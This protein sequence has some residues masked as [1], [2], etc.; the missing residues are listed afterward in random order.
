MIKLFLTTGVETEE[1][2]PPQQQSNWQPPA[3]EHPVRGQT[4]E[5]LTRKKKP[6]TT[7]A[8][9]KCLNFYKFSRKT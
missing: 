6:T 9:L 1:S 7:F 3:M 5:R 2:T 8:D 4:A